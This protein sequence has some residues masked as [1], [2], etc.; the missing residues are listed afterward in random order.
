[1]SY[2][3]VGRVFSIHIWDTRLTIYFEDPMSFIPCT[4]LYVVA[5]LAKPAT[6]VADGSLNRTRFEEGSILTN[7]V[8]EFHPDV[9][10]HSS[11]VG[12]ILVCYSSIQYLEL[13]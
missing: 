12:L 5:F 2:F 11:T 1:M 13:R 8:L 9:P 10:E 6:I 7:I 4:V 3:M